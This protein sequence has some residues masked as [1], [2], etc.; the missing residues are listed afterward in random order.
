MAWT[1]SVSIAFAV[2]SMPSFSAISIRLGC[3][4]MPITEAPI[5]RAI[6]TVYSP[7]GPSPLTASVM[8]PDARALR[9]AANPVPR[10]QASSAPS[11]KSKS[12]GSGRVLRA[13]T[14]TNSAFT[15]SRT[16]LKPCISR[17]KPGSPR[18]QCSQWPQPIR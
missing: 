17:Q 13:G 11:S 4:S 15:P 12:S 5:A 10:L 7:T 18:R 8:S 1:G 9:A 16:Q 14:T 3:T 2:A 6:I